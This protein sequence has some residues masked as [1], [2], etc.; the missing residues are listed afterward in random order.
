MSGEGDYQIRVNLG[1]KARGA[2]P[3]T[4]TPSCSPPLLALRDH[5]RLTELLPPIGPRTIRKR[6][7]ISFN[8]IEAL[9]C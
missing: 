8:G 5:A 2:I 3:S 6:P 9:R 1:D 7:H 4:R